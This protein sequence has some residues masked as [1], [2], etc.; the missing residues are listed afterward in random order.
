MKVFLD[1]E[2]VLDEFFFCNLDESD[3]TGASVCKL[4]SDLMSA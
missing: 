3:L 2:S 4:R 1:D